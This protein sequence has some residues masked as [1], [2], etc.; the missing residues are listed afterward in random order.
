MTGTKLDNLIRHRYNLLTGIGIGGNAN[1]GGIVHS[2]FGQIFFRNAINR[3]AI[4]NVLHGP[5]IQNTE[6]IAS[7]KLQIKKMKDCEFL[8]I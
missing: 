8:A 6:T 4:K 2:K 7:K 5:V 1:G 3:N